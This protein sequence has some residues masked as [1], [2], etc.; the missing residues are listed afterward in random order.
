MM[1]THKAMTCL[2]RVVIVLMTFAYGHTAPAR[3]FETLASSAWV[4]DVGT[5]TVLM[6][7][8]GS[9]SLPPASMSKLMTVNMLFEALR[10]GRVTLETTF[11][12]SARATEMTARGGSTMYLQ[13]N[14]RPTVAE[15]IQ[16]MV[17]NSGNDACIVVAEGLSGTEEAFAK[18]MTERAKALG[19]EQSTFA[20]S[21]G[22]PD[23]RQRM[24]MKDLG[25][26]SR[27]LIE[28][29]PE[30]YPVF[31]QTEYN[32]KDRAPANANNRNPLLKLGI[33][34]DGLKTGHTQEAGFGLAGSVK[35]GERRII[36]AI[37]GLATDKDRASEAEKISAWAFR[38]F[39]LKTVAKADQILAQAPVFMGT[40]QTV[41]LVPAK[42]ITLLVPA[43]VQAGLQAQVIYNSPVHAPVTKGDI[44]GVLVITVPEL[45]EKRI[46]LLAAEDVGEGGFWTRLFAA[47]TVLQLRYFSDSA[48]AS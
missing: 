41:G 35:Q 12:V 5:H 1:Q 21:S 13:E 3:A 34:A 23:P 39:A 33:G 38:Q 45:G 17:V 36:F 14:D 7:K 24:S 15:L 22:W 2:I 19:L 30:Y 27:R 18:Q 4:Y 43:L 28:E 29:F 11:G 48:P 10:D 42:D 9:I 46:D 16:G 44:L 8:N 26:L 31:A 40:A 37:S 20:N 32:Y 6:D 47:Y 25:M